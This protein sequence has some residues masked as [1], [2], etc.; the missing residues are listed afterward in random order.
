MLLRCRVESFDEAEIVRDWVD[1]VRR[2]REAII[3]N[4]AKDEPPKE[5]V[6]LISKGIITRLSAIADQGVE[7]KEEEDE[8]VEAEPKQ[9]TQLVPFKPEPEDETG[10]PPVYTPKEIIKLNRQHA[11]IGNLGGKC[12]IMEFVPSNVTPGAGLYAGGLSCL[13]RR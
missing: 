2:R 11:V 7:Y 6:A 8:D 9:S 5:E 3:K 4:V 12:V 13:R 1:A 10:P